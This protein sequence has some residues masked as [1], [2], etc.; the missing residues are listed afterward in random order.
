MDF[1]SILRFF[2][3]PVLYVFIFYMYLLY[4]RQ[5]GIER[6]L[7]HAR[8]TTASLELLRSIGYG[9]IGGLGASVLLIAFGVAL[10]YQEMLLLWIVSVVLALFSVRFLSFAY[11]GGLLGILAFFAP[12]FHIGGTGILPSVIDW[13]NALHV[14]SILALVAVLH[15]VEG[16]LMHSKPEKG[17]S[18]V[19]IAGKRGRAIGAFQL[20][21]F[22]LLPL[23]IFMPGST[24]AGFSFTGLPSWVPWFYSGSAVLSL[25][26]VPS[27]VGYMDVAVTMPPFEK[28]KQSGKKI[29][30]W[31]IALFIIAYAAKYLPVF[32]LIG[33]LLSLFSHELI[34]IYGRL[35]EKQI[36]PLYVQLKDG[37]RVLAVIPGSP[38]DEMGIVTG[39]VIIKVNGVNV[40]DKDD[41]YPALQRQSAFCKMEVKNQK[42][43][44]KYVQR[45]LY[46]GEH[47][48]LGIVLAPDASVQR[49][50]KPGQASIVDLFRRKTYRLGGTGKIPPQETHVEVAQER[51][52]SI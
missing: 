30:W 3:N 48:E 20:N 49:Y 37:V 34:R 18:P 51:D 12:W 36:S 5:V 24:G 4:R 22:W 45:S 19:Y 42:G 47:H 29:I 41:I 38:A 14:P 25:L 52:V 31:G 27:V 6:R 15:I 10:S 11:A 7:F 23:F 32:A 9:V 8:M 26:P 40:L 50:V 17:A 13:V 1:W 46:Q 2:I 33:S 21:K 43:Y 44:I 35:R 39:D 16:L 28:S